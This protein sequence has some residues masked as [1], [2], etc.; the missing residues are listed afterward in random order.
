[1]ETL[2]S[3]IFLV[4]G[5]GFFIYSIAWVD[6]MQRRDRLHTD[7]RDDIAYHRMLQ[8]RR[9]FGYDKVEKAVKSRPFFRP[10]KFK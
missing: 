4:F 5:L 8:E 6:S 1:M 10:Y 2:T 9:E 3:S 7:K